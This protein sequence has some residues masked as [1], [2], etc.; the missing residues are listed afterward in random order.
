MPKKELK[1]EI[2]GKLDPN[3]SKTRK[4]MV[5]GAHYLCEN[6]KCVRAFLGKS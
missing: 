3:P 6:N 1:C 2:C 5:R 4:K